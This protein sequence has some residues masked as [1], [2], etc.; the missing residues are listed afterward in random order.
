MKI[1]RVCLL[2]YSGSVFLSSAHD[3]NA[4]RQQS[5][6]L[7]DRGGKESTLQEDTMGKRTDRNRETE[8]YKERPRQLD[9]H[10]ETER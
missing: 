8:V 2:I 5:R 9:T 4:M 3:P 1:E 10:R 7:G 6:S